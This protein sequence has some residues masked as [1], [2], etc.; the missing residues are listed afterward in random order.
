MD[1]TPEYIR[2]ELGRSPIGNR[3][4][5]GWSV[6]CSCGWKVTTNENKR[7]AETLHRQHV[8]APVMTAR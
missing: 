2:R 7:R 5:Y 4:L 6:R 3:P 8:K 1:H